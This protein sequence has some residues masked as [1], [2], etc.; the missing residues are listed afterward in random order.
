M[1]LIRQQSAYIYKHLSPS[2]SQQHF[3]FEL[4]KVRHSVRHQFEL[5]FTISIP[6]LWNDG[7][8]TKTFVKFWNWHTHKHTLMQ[9]MSE[10]LCWYTKHSY[11]FRN[12]ECNSMRNVRVVCAFYIPEFIFNLL[13]TTNSVRCDFDCFNFELQLN[14]R[15]WLR[16]EW[17]ICIFCCVF[18]FPSQRLLTIRVHCSNL[19]H[20]YVSL[21][22]EHLIANTLVKIYNSIEWHSLLI[23]VP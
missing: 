20:I 7:H 14:Q 21:S 6:N 23:C 4:Y 22:L 15:I 3:K 10:Q 12:S 9:R 18:V 17:S 13:I 19:T 2:A 11:K 16:I 5:K 1:R 8:K